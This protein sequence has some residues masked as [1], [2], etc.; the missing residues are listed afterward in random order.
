[1]PKFTLDA[2]VLVHT[3][4]PPN[5]AKIISIPSYDHPDIYMVIFSYESLA[6]YCDNI[7]EAAPSIHS[8]VSNAILPS[9]IQGGANATLFLNDMAKPHYR[10]LFQHSD[11]QW[12]FCTGKFFNLSK[13]IELPANCQVILDTAQVFCGH[14]KFSKVYQA[15]SQI[16]L[17]DCVLQH[18]SDH[19]LQSLMAPT[20]H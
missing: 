3:H 16:Q 10:K 18:V 9:W 20:S 15:R 5:M 11:G 12:F 14:T 2:D 6:E 4:S 1:M 17:H 7:L 19:G 8:L 13:S